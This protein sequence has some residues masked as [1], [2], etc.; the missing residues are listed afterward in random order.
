MNINLLHQKATLKGY[1]WLKTILIITV[2]FL[3]AAQKAPFV[4]K[5]IARG[6]P[7]HGANGIT[8]DAGDNLYIASV[9]GREIVVMNSL[10]GNIINH[11]GTGVGVEGPDD[12]TFGPDGSLYWTS[13]TTGEVGRLS[14]EGVKT[15]QIVAPGVN[16]ITFSS[17]GRLFVALDFL[18]DGL[19]ELDPELTDPPRPIIVA[20]ESNP[21]PLGFLNGFD[22]GP[23][24]R[25]YG[26]L[27]AV[28]IVVSIDVDSCVNTS[29]PWVD[30][31][32]RVVAGGFTVPAAAKFDARGRLHVVDQSGEVFQ[33]ET[34][35]GGKT[36]I[37][38]L[39]PGLDNLAF[40]SDGNLFITNANDGSVSRVLPSGQ[41]RILS[42]GGMILPGGVAVI[43][44]AHGGE[45]VFVA[46]VWTLREFNGLTGR[47]VSLAS[48]SLVGEGLASPLTVSEDGDRLVLSSWIQGAVQVWDPEAGQILEHYPMAA[49]LNAIRFQDDLVVA[50]LGLGGLVWASTQEMILGQ[51]D[52]FVPAG[53]AA[54]EDTLWVADWATGIVWQVGFDGKTPLTPVSVAF[55]LVMPEGLAL[56]LDGSLLVVEAGA[57]RLSR[58]DLPTGEVSVVADALKLGAPTI[59]GT[60]PTYQFNGVTVGPSGAIYVTGDVTNVLYRIWPR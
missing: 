27:F 5:E 30:C 44:R 31:D 22:F 8:I 28:G 50:D 13:I 10:T 59:P 11:L 39:S 56:D 45:S 12:L 49:P 51:P 48:G 7:I 3:T 14:P 52:V 36:V 15:G 42:E 33:V 9:W 29:D 37:A 1:P 34:T 32:I 35:T 17:D 54:T 58:L 47:P 2:V 19:Y 6:S 38:T 41:G 18:G 43:P 26:P 4:L 60:P 25:L 16:P 23:D 21:F 53:L 57:G 55:D 40:D 20:T 24:G 46:D